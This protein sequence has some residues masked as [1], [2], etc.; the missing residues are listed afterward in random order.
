MPTIE[1]RCPV[2]IGVSL[3]LVITLLPYYYS[4]VPRKAMDPRIFIRDVVTRQRPSTYSKVPSK[5][6]DP[7]IEAN[8][9]TTEAMTCS[10]IASPYIKNSCNVRKSQQTTWF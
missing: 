7:R 5:A 9:G 6:T 10:P 3:T 2:T 8:T 4:K 1:N